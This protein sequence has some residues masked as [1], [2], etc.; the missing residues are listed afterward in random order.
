MIA[1]KHTPHH[2]LR[3]TISKVP[4]LPWAKSNLFLLS[5]WIFLGKAHCCSHTFSDFAPYLCASPSA[6]D[7]PTSSIISFKR[8]PPENNKKNIP[9]LS[10]AS[11][12]S[13]FLAR[14]FISWKNLSEALRTNDVFPCSS[15]CHSSDCFSLVWSETAT[16]INVVRTSSKIQWLPGHSHQFQTIRKCWQILRF[17]QHA[18]LRV[19]P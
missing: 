8:T 1:L 12:L 13:S 14:T 2:S 11:C 16:E 18:S 3:Y 10:H 19:P 9:F 6:S 7:T 5:Y 17:S 15:P 4:Y